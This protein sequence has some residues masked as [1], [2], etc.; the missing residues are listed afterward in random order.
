MSASTKLAAK[1]VCIPERLSLSESYPAVAGSIPR[2]RDAVVEFAHAAGLAG[3]ELDALRLALTEAVTNAVLHGF[4][5]TAGSVQVTAALAGGELWVLVADDGCGF[6]HARRGSRGM[7][8]GLAL[9]ADACEDF[10][11]AERAG[12][13]TELRMSFAVAEPALS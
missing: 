4:D 5:A 11:I 6:L 12:G 10:E 8:W 1:L 2:A 3:A 7:G 9:I 13:G